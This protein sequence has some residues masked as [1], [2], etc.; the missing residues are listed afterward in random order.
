MKTVG[1]FKGFDQIA[2]TSG[3]LSLIVFQRIK[4]DGSLI[5]KKFISRI[6]IGSSLIMKK[7]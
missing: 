2:R 3:S 7:I 4:I 5:M 1:T 6:E